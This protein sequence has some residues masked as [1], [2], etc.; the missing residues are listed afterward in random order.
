MLVLTRKTDQSIT[1]GDPAS[2]D[3]AIEI[4]VVEIRGGEVRLGIQ[5][6][7]SV[8]VHRKEVWEQ[9]QQE[10]EATSKTSADAVQRTPFEGVPAARKPGSTAGLTLEEIRRRKK[11]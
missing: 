6:P 4:T 7:K 3:A 11:M 9:V 5:A 1:L 2:A 8:V 10:N